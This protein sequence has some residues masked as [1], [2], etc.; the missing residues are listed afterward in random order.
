MRLP[1][2]MKVR[3]GT[4][5]WILRQAF[6]D[7]LPGYIARRPKNP[8]SHSSG[9]HERV[10]MYK[11]LFA[12]IHR[13]FGYDLHEPVR[14]DFSTVLARCGND[15]DRA[16]AGTVGDYSPREHARDFA[17]AVRWNAATALRSAWRR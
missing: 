7:L 12:R 1:M 13:S 16:C 8:L 9:L 11:P 15:L 10:R 17:G 4:E 3:D 5:K 2:T 14:K 6:A